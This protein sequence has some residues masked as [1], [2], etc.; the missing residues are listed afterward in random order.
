MLLNQGESLNPGMHFI[1]TFSTIK[2]WPD[3]LQ[4]IQ[5]YEFLRKSKSDN[6]ENDGGNVNTKLGTKARGW[7]ACY[8]K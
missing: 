7:Q 2:K 5:K 6:I 4:T 8:R 1:V 3:C